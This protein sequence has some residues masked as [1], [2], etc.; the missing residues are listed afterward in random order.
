MEGNRLISGGDPKWLPV[1]PTNAA[2]SSASAIVMMGSSPKA[3]SHVLDFEQQNSTVSLW[4]KDNKQETVDAA[5]AAARAAVGQVGIDH[6]KFRV[7]LGTGTIALQ[8]SMNNVVK[9]YHWVVIGLLNLMILVGCSYAYKSV[10]AGLLLLIPVNL[11]NFALNATMHLLGIGLDINS[12]MVASLGVGVGI[13]YGIYLLSRICEEFHAHEGDWGQAITASLMT[14][15]KA[16]MFT[17][18]IMLIS[19]VPWYFLAGLKFMADMGLLLTMVMLIN[20]VLALI[21]LPLLVW[22]VKPGFVARKDLFVGEGVDLSQLTA[23]RSELAP[24]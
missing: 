6:D 12:L 23:A 21:V 14:T 5:L 2:T 1:D 20:M 4:Y 15:G 7:R 11:S 8:Q 24:A 16:I 22:V 9:R 17:A 19:I 13:D 3:F 10:L 18:S